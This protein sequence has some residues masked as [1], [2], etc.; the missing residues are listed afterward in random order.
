MFQTQLKQ[1]LEST[2]NVY[3]LEVEAEV[4]EEISCFL[5][6]F[7][8]CT[9]FC[10]SLYRSSQAQAGGCN[11]YESCQDPRIGNHLQLVSSST[12]AVA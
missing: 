8:F 9:D 12:V 10:F 2:W 11:A 3:L 4:V 6:P 7:D 1:E 5:I